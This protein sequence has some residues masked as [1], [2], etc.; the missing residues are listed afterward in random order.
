[1]LKNILDARIVTPTIDRDDADTQK[2]LE[3]IWEVY[4]HLS[5]IQLSNMTHDPNGAWH[6]A[7]DMARGRHGYDISDDLIKNEFAE[8]SKRAA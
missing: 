4:G 8:K 7:W 5:G 2:F 3:K 6:K 1:M